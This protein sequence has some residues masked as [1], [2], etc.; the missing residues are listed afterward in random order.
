MVREYV[1]HDDEESDEL[2]EEELSECGT[3]DKLGDENSRDEASLQ[4]DDA[5]EELLDV[6]ASPHGKA[7]PLVKSNPWIYGILTAM[8]F[9]AFFVSQSV[10]KRRE[11]VANM[12]FAFELMIGWIVRLYNGKCWVLPIV[13]LSLWFWRC[14]APQGIWGCVQPHQAPVHEKKPRKI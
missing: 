2:D 8:T 6:L 1:T 9:N 13:V 5:Y 14:E 7:L 10:V 3:I 4:G 11:L 12:E